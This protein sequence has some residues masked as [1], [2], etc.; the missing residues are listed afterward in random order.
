METNHIAP[1]NLDFYKT[2]QISNELIQSEAPSEIS[3]LSPSLLEAT[4]DKEALNH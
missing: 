2:T 1:Y 3:I 4:V